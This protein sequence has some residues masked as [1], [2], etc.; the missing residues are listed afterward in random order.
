[1]VP[2]GQYFVGTALDVRDVHLDFGALP[3]AIETPEPLLEQFRVERQIK[4]HEMMGELK[5]TP[6]ASDFGTDQ[7]SCTVVLRE[8]RRVAVAFDQGKAFVKDG[9][10]EGQTL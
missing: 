7:Q 5:I 4:Q 6:F 1:M 8:P 10:F 9:H 2:T 3:D